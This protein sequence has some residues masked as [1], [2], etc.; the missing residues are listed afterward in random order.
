MLA[1]N[2]V[3]HPGIVNLNAILEDPVDAPLLVTAF[4]AATV[5]HPGPSAALV[6]AA[7]PDPIEP[8]MFS[9]QDDGDSSETANSIVYSELAE[10]GVTV[11][12]TYRAWLSDRWW[13]VECLT[14]PGP[15]RLAPTLTVF[16]GIT[17]VQRMYRYDGTH[18]IEINILELPDGSHQTISRAVP[19]MVYLGPPLSEPTDLAGF[20]ETR[21]RLVK[22]PSL[23]VNTAHFTANEGTTVTVSGT[24]SHPDGVAGTVRLESPSQDPSEVHVDAGGSFSLS[25][26][27]DN[28][29]SRAGTLSSLSDEGVPSELVNLSATI[30]NVAPKNGMI[31]FTGEDGTHSNFNEGELLTATVT[32][33]DPGADSHLIYIEWGDGDIYAGANRSATHRYASGLYT[34]SFRIDD[35]TNGVF[36]GSTTV[37]INAAPELFLIPAVVGGKE[38]A[39]VQ[40]SGQIDDLADSPTVSVSWGDGHSSSATIDPVFGLVQAAHTYLDEGSFVATL[41][42]R[43]NTGFE[44]TPVVV[45][46]N[47]RNADPT[48]TT[49][50]LLRSD[51]SSEIPADGIPPGIGVKPSV[52]AT[53][54]GTLDTLTYTVNWGDG[55]PTQGFGPTSPPTHNYAA[56]GHYTV[57]LAVLDND[58][59][60]TEAPISLWIN[61]LPTLIGLPAGAA[62]DEGTG[63][64]IDGTLVDPSAGATRVDVDWGDGTT[65]QINLPASNRSMHAAHTYPAD[66]GTW[67]ARFTPV[68]VFGFSGTP[69][70]VNVT[71]R[72]V[73]PALTD[74]DLELGDG[75]RANRVLPGQA[76]TAVAT[77]SDPGILDTHTVSVDWGD[78]TVTTSPDLTHT[79]AAEGGYAVR[80]KVG[81]DNG[82]DS[83]TKLLSLLVNTP[84]EITGL[85]ATIVV[86][87]GSV[88]TVAGTLIDVSPGAAFVDVTWS[89]GPTDLLELT[90]PGDGPFS[91]QREGT[92]DSVWTAT[93]TPLDA[94]GTSNSAQNVTVVVNNVPPALGRIM[95]LSADGSPLPDAGVL[96]ARP[97]TIPVSFTDPGTRD[98]FEVIVDWGDGTSDI[99][100]GPQVFAH[101]WTE[102]AEITITVTVRDDDGGQDV[103]AIPVRVRSIA[104][105]AGDTGN[106][107]N[108]LAG[109]IADP[110]LAD[111][112]GH[113]ARLLSSATRI[114]DAI[115]LLESDRSGAAALKLYRATAILHRLARRGLPVEGFVQALV[116]AL[117][118]L[119][120][121]TLAET[122][123]TSAVSARRLQDTQRFFDQGVAAAAA[124]DWMK[125]ARSYRD[126]VN[127]LSR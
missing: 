46:V 44:G 5:P 31:T 77:F 34:V 9:T 63:V 75:S 125:A 105:V 28:D 62:V 115:D 76:V 79:Y 121:T 123:S 78:G 14:S 91:I 20:K 68:D 6:T 59:G 107:L 95:L 29:P 42:P 22:Q 50:K 69:V 126:V 21:A 100:S 23:H 108:A 103:R 102:A 120:G 72:N 74:A 81:D 83:T 35:Q 11:N 99:A 4:A 93:L 112:I 17:D 47:I 113:A 36:E 92:D 57:T 94:F 80:V 119:A 51:N 87:E 122:R 88:V 7:T 1:L 67:T 124:G 18:F 3:D 70:N 8:F 64:S 65:S 24:Y 52:Q 118:N 114:R 106:D 12:D 2:E 37:D 32:F 84:P 48:I 33:T 30:S 16:T 53:D 61:T 66:D 10:D 109:E 111:A 82:A 19:E 41:I 104:G 110:S 39:A 54:A 45:A 27:L 15:R 73:A 85:P 98:E 60:R 116:D 40:L 97:V 25:W 26:L 101:A 38:G 56:E 86:D 117:G 89:D 49:A 43:D 13:V 71:V 58:S 90:I 127:R 96:V 55:S